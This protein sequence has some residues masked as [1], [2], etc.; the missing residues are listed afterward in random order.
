MNT[1]KLKIE[2]MHCAS[3]AMDIDGE[4]EDTEGIENSN[5]SYAKSVAEVSFDPVKITKDKIL[6][7]VEKIGYKASITDSNSSQDE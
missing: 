3:C 5:T 2:G 6:G 4:L 7:I 1:I